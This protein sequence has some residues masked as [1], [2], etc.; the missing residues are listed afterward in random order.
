MAG[1]RVFEQSLE[2][3]APFGRM[4]T[5]GIATREQ[6]ELRTG[7]LMRRSWTVSG[8]WFMHCLREPETMMRAPLRDLFER[9]ASGGLRA[10]VGE[11]YPLSDVRRAHEDIAARRTSGKL[12]LDPSA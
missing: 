1:G 2:A 8:F 5:Y 3:M 11:T 10:V 6:N 4:V 7:R 9:A 12:L